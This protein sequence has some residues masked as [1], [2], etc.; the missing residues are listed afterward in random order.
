M[1]HILVIAAKIGLLKPSLYKKDG[2]TYDFKMLDKEFKKKVRE[3]LSFQIGTT[4]ECSIEIR[5]KLDD[6]G[7]IVNSQYCI[8][9]V[10]N[11]SV[12]SDYK[13]EMPSGVKRRYKKL[14]G[15]QLDF[16]M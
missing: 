11:I 1:V 6:D 2:K 7:D 12:N 14:G 4:L 3:G 9:E 5:R 13:V 8:K 10:F 16:F 15:G